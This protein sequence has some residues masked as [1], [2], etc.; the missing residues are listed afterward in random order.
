[1]PAPLLEEIAQL[2]QK[3]EDWIRDDQTTAYGA[4]DLHPLSEHARMPRKGEDYRASF[5][6]SPALSINSHVHAAVALI[7]GTAHR[8]YRM[9]PGQGFRIHSDDYFGGQSSR[10]LYLNRNWV[11]DWGGLLHVIEADSCRVV[12]PEF[13][14]LATMDYAQGKVPH[15]VSQVAPWALEPRYILSVFGGS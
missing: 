7:G 11:W 1:M 4:D 10:I 3:T 5:F 12:F 9:E 15:F 2:Y 13:N 8:C 6:H 14:L